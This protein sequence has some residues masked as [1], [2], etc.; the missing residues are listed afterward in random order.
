MVGSANLNIM[1]KAAR[2]AGRALVK[3]FREV[4]QR[5]KVKTPRAAGSLIR[6]TGRRIFCTVCHIGRYLSRL[7]IKGRLWPVL[8]LMR[9]RK[10]C[11]SPKKVRALG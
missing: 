3:D 8:C 11:F 5:K 4:E 1:I 7:S 6:W 9:P 10:R 2:K